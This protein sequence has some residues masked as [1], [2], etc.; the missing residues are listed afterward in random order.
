MSI[1][2]AIEHQRSLLHSPIVE[3][4]RSAVAFAR[5]PDFA[6]MAVTREEYLEMGS[7]ATRRRFRDWKPSNQDGKA[8]ETQRG[9]EEDD[10]APVKKAVRGRGR[11]ASAASGVARRRTQG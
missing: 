2:N 8:K 11:G 4:Y 9:D 7:N 1:F 3:A 5:S 10:S 6:R